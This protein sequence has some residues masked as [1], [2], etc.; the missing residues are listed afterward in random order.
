VIR[1][2]HRDID[3]DAARDAAPAE[4]EG[5]EEHRSPGLQAALAGHA[6]RVG[7]R[8]L[9]LGP[10]VPAN[11]AFLSRFASH[12]CIADLMDDGGDAADADRWRGRLS[13]A[14]GPFDLVLVWDL[15]SRL[16]RERTDDL[17]TQLQRAT[18]PGSVLFLLIHEA[19]D[20]PAAAPVFE[21]RDDDR[22]AYRASGSDSTPTPKIPPAEVAR[23]LPCFRVDASFILRH[24]IR[25]YVAVRV[26]CDEDHIS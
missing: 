14:R 20:M 18:R 13:E 16:D 17:V 23:R 6:A 24:G 21:I 9:D 19:A 11:V 3:A 7:C 8:V 1:F 26:R 12:L 2:R 22:I 5:V 25:E 10:A 4:A 15:L